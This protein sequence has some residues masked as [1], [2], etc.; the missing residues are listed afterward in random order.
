VAPARR[1]W[2]RWR[3]RHLT[4]S[5][6]EWNRCKS[7]ANRAISTLL[8]ISRY[9]G[10]QWTYFPLTVSGQYI[11]VIVVISTVW[12]G[13][14]AETNAERE[15]SNQKD[16]LIDMEDLIVTVKEVEGESNVK[17]KRE[18]WTKTSVS[19]K[20]TGRR[21]GTKLVL[22]LDFWRHRGGERKITRREDVKILG[23]ALPLKRHNSSIKVVASRPK[24]THWMQLYDRKRYSEAKKL[25]RDKVYDSRRGIKPVDQF[26]NGP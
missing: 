15:Q 26:P 21:Y 11:K 7:S 13:L 25:M 5:R 12:K 2:C 18:D 16:V 17:N 10:V 20:K 4:G 19:V 23:V 24:E 3:T 8:L 1:R 6:A 22:L 9:L 14:V